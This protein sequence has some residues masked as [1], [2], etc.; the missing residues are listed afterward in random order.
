MPNERYR[1]ANLCLHKLRIYLQS[2]VPLKGKNKK[3]CQ[4]I[5]GRQHRTTPAGQIL[6]V[7]T[8]A[9]PAALTLMGA[10]GHVNQWLGAAGVSLCDCSVVNTITLKCTVL[11]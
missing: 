7:A 10:H 2:E 6:G 3:H 8:P 9:T 5:E 1:L 11:S 4:N